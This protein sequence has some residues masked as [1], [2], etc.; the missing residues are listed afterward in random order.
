LKTEEIRLKG[1]LTEAASRY[2][3]R[4]EKEGRSLVLLSNEL[5]RVLDDRSVFVMF[6]S[7]IIL[8]KV[9]PSLVDPPPNI[10]LHE[11]LELSYDQALRDWSK[12]TATIKTIAFALVS[13]GLAFALR[14]FLK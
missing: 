14:R 3:Q 1:S 5:S 10:R 4:Q 8:N 9:I 12:Q 11:S 13:A 7:S 6:I 2:A